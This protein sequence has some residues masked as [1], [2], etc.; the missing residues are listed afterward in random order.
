MDKGFFLG[1]SFDSSTLRVSSK[2]HRSVSRLPDSRS[3]SPPEK[4]A[5]LK[6]EVGSGMQLIADD[7]GKIKTA[8]L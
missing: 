2:N 7:L 6:I 4:E 1:N 5:L 8:F 3:C